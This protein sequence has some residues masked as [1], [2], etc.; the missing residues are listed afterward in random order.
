MTMH[1]WNDN[2]MDLFYIGDPNDMHA[3]FDMHGPHDRHHAPPHR[4]GPPPDDLWD[5]QPNELPPPPPDFEEVA[6]APPI[7]GRTPKAGSLNKTG[8]SLKTFGSER[9]FSYICNQKQ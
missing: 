9:P 6:E 7:F 3:P 5:G 1:V 8:R 2:L 4:Q